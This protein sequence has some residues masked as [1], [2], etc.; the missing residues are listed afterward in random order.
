MVSN[1]FVFIAIMAVAFLSSCATTQKIAALKPEADDATP[2]IYDSTP[3]FVNLPISLKISEIEQ[4]VNLKLNGLIYEDLKMEGDDLIL[5]VWKQ[6]P[7][8][9]KNVNGKI[10]TLLPLKIYA[11][12]RIGTS[13]LGVNLYR[14]N[15]FNLNG[16]IEL[17][18]DV[19]LK[20]WKLSTKT[21]FK[22]IKWKES[23]TTTVMGKEVSITYLINPALQI[24]KDDI[25]K[26]IDDAIEESMDFKPNV[27]DALEK[28]STPTLMNEAYET[29]VKVAP[30][31]LYA[32]DALMKNQEIALQMG[33][34]CLIE[35]TIGSKPIN[36]FNR[37]KIVLKS[38]QSM[39]NTIST[40]IVAIS[41]Y[42][43][44]SKIITKNFVGQVFGE[45]NKKVTVNHVEIWHKSDKIVVALN[46]SGSFDG[47]IYLAGFPKYNEQTKEIYF[48]DLDYVLDT[49]SKLIKTANWFASGLVLKKIKELCKYSIAPNLEDGKRIM[50]QYTQNYSP[51]KG[52]YINGKMGEIKFK[53]MQL[54]NK[55]LIAFLNIEGSLKVTIDGL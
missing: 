14:D 15:E 6:A 19:S 47:T 34:K 22:N 2:L 3:S 42:A 12:Y 21:A 33:M 48:D 54:S 17:S 1:K 49:K 44:A 50:A 55:A 35:T 46:M 13:K 16:T 25:E 5:K 18:S 28:L 53:E 24:F 31:E 43:D 9:I 7:I 51:M 38:V 40:N 4:Q 23:P 41:T 27:L 45:G 11:K 37:D 8:K 10:Q 52:V 26:A 30:I 36:N 32:T 39:P 20:N 29:W